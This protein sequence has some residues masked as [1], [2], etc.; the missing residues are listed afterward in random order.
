MAQKP[1]RT[2]RPRIYEKESAH[3]ADYSLRLARWWEERP[4]LERDGHILPRRFEPDHQ[5]A[6]LE[7]AFENDG[8]GDGPDFFSAL[9]RQRLPHRD[10]WRTAPRWSRR[11]SGGHDWILWQ[12]DHPEISGATDVLHTTSECAAMD[13]FSVYA[14]CA[15]LNALQGL[16]RMA[17]SIG[18]H[19]SADLWRAR[20]EKMREAIGARYLVT[21][22]KYGRIWTLDF[23]GWPHQGHR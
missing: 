13:G 15:C 4:N 1:A 2:D 14:D 12:F 8:H 22:P 3:S 11:E 7:A 6:G 23:A 16:A 17:D 19:R 10:E 20:A 9:R 21:D 5:P 18:E